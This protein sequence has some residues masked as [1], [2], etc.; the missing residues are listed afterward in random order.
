[1][2]ADLSGFTLSS[3]S[4][5]IDLARQWPSGGEEGESGA[6]FYFQ[7][8]AVSSANNASWTPDDDGRDTS[9]VYAEYSRGEGGALR[10]SCSDKTSCRVM[11]AAP[12]FNMRYGTGGNIT[13]KSDLRTLSKALGFGY[14][15][16]DSY[17]ATF[18]SKPPRH[19]STNRRGLAVDKNGL[20]KAELFIY[21]NAFPRR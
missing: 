12:M 14:I 9:F 13:Y 18:V 8:S 6:L 20:G 4:G 11:S 17:G 16:E 1:M 21:D 7:K 2:A 15:K 10:N 5:T 3:T 19:N